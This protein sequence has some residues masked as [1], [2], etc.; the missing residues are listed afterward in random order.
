[1]REGYI[2][3]ARVRIFHSEYQRK[4]V[5]S[6]SEPS[7]SRVPEEDSSDVHSDSDNEV[8]QIDFDSQ[9]EFTLT[10]NLNSLLT[11]QFT[12]PKTAMNL[13]QTLNYYRHV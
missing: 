3:C 11:V 4:L 10:V 9:F 2:I 7:T 13:S 8:S 1:M 5:M 12:G 6:P